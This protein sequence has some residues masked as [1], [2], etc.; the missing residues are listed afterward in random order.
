MSFAPAA[1]DNVTV[2]VEVEPN[3]LFAVEGNVIVLPPVAS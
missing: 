1:E 2:V 3:T